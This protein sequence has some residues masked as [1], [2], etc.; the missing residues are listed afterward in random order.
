[1]KLPFIIILLFGGLFISSIPIEQNI[2]KVSDTKAFLEDPIDLKSFKLAKGMSNSGGGNSQGIYYIPNRKGFFY[3]YMYFRSFGENGPY[4]LTY[5]N[6]S[7]VGSY[8]K[9]NEELI[10]I[11]SN[12]SDSD[13]MNLNLVN[14]SATEIKSIFG[15]ANFESSSSIIYWNKNKILIHFIQNGKVKWF[16]YAKLKTEINEI[17]D[18]KTE[19][20]TRFIY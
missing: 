5:V 13:L 15:K 7:V 2:S 11:K 17:A 8:H 9:E 18:L 3:R 10:E 20:Y 6:G 12:R 19:L 1:M 4:I 16:R 14:K